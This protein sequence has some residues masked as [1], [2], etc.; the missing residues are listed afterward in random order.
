MTFYLFLKVIYLIKS[1]QVLDIH[2]PFQ[3][4]LMYPGS[5]VSSMH[6]CII[7]GV[8]EQIIL[9]FYLP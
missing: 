7:H 3:V 6:K 5:I 8:G 2:T 1:Q 9:P 4:P